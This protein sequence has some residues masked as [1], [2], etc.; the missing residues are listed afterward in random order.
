MELDTKSKVQRQQGS[1]ILQPKPPC[2]DQ[3]DH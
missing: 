2:E 1:G 3:K